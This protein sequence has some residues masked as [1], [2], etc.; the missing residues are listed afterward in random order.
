MKW[1]FFFLKKKQLHRSKMTI[2]INTKKK[3]EDNLSL[4]KEFYH[5]GIWDLSCFSVEIKIMMKQKQRNEMKWN[6]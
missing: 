4:D 1:I 6:E 5:Q 3:T 2:V